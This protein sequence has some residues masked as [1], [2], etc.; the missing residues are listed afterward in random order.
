MKAKELQIGDW[1]YWGEQHSNI[2]GDYDFSFEPHKITMADFVWLYQNNWEDNE[3]LEF[4]KPIKLDEEI[5]KLN[6]FFEYNPF[7]TIDY[8]MYAFPEQCNIKKERG[9]GIEIGNGAVYITDHCLM[10]IIYVHNLQHALKQCGLSEFA[11]NFK[12]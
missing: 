5:L 2:D 10:P 8:K 6:G 9:F 12:M 3:E 11:N 7:K 1:V 4:V